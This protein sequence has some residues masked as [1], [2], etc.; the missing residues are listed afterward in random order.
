MPSDAEP[1]HVE[2]GAEPPRA[3]RPAVGVRGSWLRR[4]GRAA[5]AL[6]I[7]ACWLE[8]VPRYLFGISPLTKES[9]V[10]R[11]DPEL[12][13]WHQPNAHG[14]F[15]KIDCRQT[16][17]INSHGLREREIGYQKPEGVTRILVLGNS[18]TVGFEV[19]REQVFTRVMEE[20]L[21]RL[22]CKA[23][24]LNAACRGWGSDQALLYL[25]REG[26]KYR[27]DLVMYCTGGI[28]LATNMELHRPYREFGKGYF[29]LGDDDA[30]ELRNVPVPRYPLDVEM[31][32]DNQ[33]EVVSQKCPPSQGRWLWFRDKVVCRSVACTL[34]LQV[35]STVPMVARM[36]NGVGFS[37][38][39]PGRG[40]GLDAFRKGLPCR[41]TVATYLAMKREAKAVG[42]GFAICSP[43]TINQGRSAP[44]EAM[45][46][47]AG[48]PYWDL[49]QEAKDWLAQGVSFHLRH[50]AHF[51]EIGHR[52]IGKAIAR[53]LV[54]RGLVPAAGPE[55]GSGDASGVS[56]P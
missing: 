22:G 24:V 16:I 32:L 37:P 39:V 26:L 38:S 9:V 17:D 52:E 12:G 21:A 1:Q 33:G 55:A 27:P 19:P 29:A 46:G 34:A 6:A 8:V 53:S 50:D 2:Q 35:L 13:W 40:E 47:A 5:L 41:L 54:R 45:I 48:E 11:Y 23:Q 28:E 44:D 51:N 30:L 56:R 42:A 3:D 31:H 18:V 43:S 36:I 10:W 49:G 14:T 7:V 25:R 15:V 4:L 20:E